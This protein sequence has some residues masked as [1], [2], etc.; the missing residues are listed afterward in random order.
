MN[1]PICG[2]PLKDN[3]L[4][5]NNCGTKRTEMGAAYN[6]TTVQN[7]YGTG[8]G[9]N[10]NNTYNSPYGQTN[11]Y[12]NNY[13][14]QNNSNY[15]GFGMNSSPTRTISSGND[16]RKII[17]TIVMVIVLL[18][19]VFG[20]RTYTNSPKEVRMADITITLPQHMKKQSSSIYSDAE[21]DG[22]EFYLNNNVGFAYLK[23]DMKD[24]GFDDETGD[25]LKKL[26]ITTMDTTFAATNGGLSGYEKI[27][28]VD[29]HLRFY[30]TESGERFYSDMKIDVHDGE[31]YMFVVYCKRISENRFVGKFRTMYDTLEYN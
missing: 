30:F 29:D 1:C 31:I 26:F 22:G 11:S 12:N 27:D 20:Y 8:Y 21:A 14:A 6:Q 2:T 24:L 5:C 18:I 15:N 10:A 7:S 23:Y 19:T 3:D 4:F 9:S 16:P 28:Q 25:A 17:I 13:N